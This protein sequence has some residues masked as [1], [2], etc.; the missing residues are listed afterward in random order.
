MRKQMS[1]LNTMSQHPSCRSLWPCLQQPVL[2]TYHPLAPYGSCSKTFRNSTGIF[3]R[4]SKSHPPPK[5]NKTHRIQNGLRLEQ[6]YWVSFPTFGEAGLQTT[7]GVPH[8][9]MKRLNGQY[10]PIGIDRCWVGPEVPWLHGQTGTPNKKVV[11]T[12]F[13]WHKLYKDVT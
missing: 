3:R 11:D 1:N 13:F 9:A 8:L 7:Q 4:F 2:P 6:N 12:C 10:L 5:K